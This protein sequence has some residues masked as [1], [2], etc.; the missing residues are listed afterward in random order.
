M[1]LPEAQ[2]AVGVR[3]LTGDGAALD[4]AAGVQWLERAASAGHGRSQ[5]RLG[6]CYANGEGVAADQAVATHLWGM[7]A[8]QVSAHPPS[9]SFTPLYSFSRYCASSV[10]RFSNVWRNS[11]AVLNLTTFP[12]HEE[13]ESHAVT[14]KRTKAY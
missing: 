10:T 3:L 13:Q 1:G 9:D 6:W 11:A 2:H 14:A 7:A 8:A 4:K 12:S 5:A